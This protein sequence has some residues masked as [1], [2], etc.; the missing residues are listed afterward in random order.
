MILLSNY[1]ETEEL[2]YYLD[3]VFSFFNISNNY[4]E[5]INILKEM[6]NVTVTLEQL[7]EHF[8]PSAS[9]IEVDLRLQF[10]HLGLV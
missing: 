8:S 7:E 1:L 6:F 3:I 4:T 2:D 5:L 9:E 10:K